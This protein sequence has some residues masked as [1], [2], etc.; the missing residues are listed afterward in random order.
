M[1]QEEDGSFIGQVYLERAE[2]GI[3]PP[4]W[5]RACNVFS[6]GGIG[7][8][9]DLVDSTT[10]CSGGFRQYIGGLSDGAEITVE[11]NYLR[12]NKDVA[13]IIKKMIQDVKA[14]RVVPYRLV[15]GDASPI[16][17]L[18]FDAL[19]LSWTINPSVD[20]RNTISF[21][22]KVSGEITLGYA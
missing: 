8:T 7:E 12:G 20:D 6:L 13:A 21:G 15:I 9:N 2:P 3:S 1:A 4:N 19:A 18:E 17:T 11:G 22:L 5:E 14:K 16:D 10:F